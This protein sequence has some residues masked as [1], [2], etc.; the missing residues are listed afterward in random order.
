MSDGPHVIIHGTVDTTRLREAVADTQATLITK[1]GLTV[2]EADARL[3]EWAD[4]LGDAG[5]EGT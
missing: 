2:E 5:H 4:N 3:R 1:G